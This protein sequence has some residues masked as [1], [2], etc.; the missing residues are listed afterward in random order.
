MYARI[1][2]EIAAT[3]EPVPSRYDR[4]SILYNLHGAARGAERGAAYGIAA[5]VGSLGMPNLFGG[6]M[7]GYKLGPT[8]AACG[9][10]LPTMGLTITQALKGLVDPGCMGVIPRPQ[11]GISAG[12]SSPSPPDSSPPLP[13]QQCLGARMKGAVKGFAEG[14]ELGLVMNI[15][16]LGLPSLLGGIVGSLYGSTG[17]LIGT[18]AFPLMGGIVTGITGFAHPEKVGIQESQCMKIS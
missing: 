2:E 1:K 10:V 16:G 13:A 3:P 12:E 6:L 15:S 11:G 8:A 9:A 4:E 7:C 17:L 18:Y 14:V 5:T